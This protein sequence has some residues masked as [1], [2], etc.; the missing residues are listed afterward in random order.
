[1]S[2]P[3]QPCRRGNRKTHDVVLEVGLTG[4]R[5]GAVFGGALVAR[6]VRL[7]VAAAVVD[8]ANGALGFVRGGGPLPSLLAAPA[9]LGAALDGLSG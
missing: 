4:G 3:P 1:M 8:A 5:T 2:K 9:M 7:A 6:V